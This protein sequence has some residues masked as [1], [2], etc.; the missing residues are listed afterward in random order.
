M[1]DQQTQ[2][3]RAEANDV[4]NRVVNSKPVLDNDEIL[5]CYSSLST[6][7]YSAPNSLPPRNK[8][9]DENLLYASYNKVGNYRRQSVTNSIN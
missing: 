6:A 4:R 7:V 3:N 2:S 8:S 1:L 9:D 5:K